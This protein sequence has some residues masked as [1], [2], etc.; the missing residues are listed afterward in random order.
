MIQEVEET[1]AKYIKLGVLVVIVLVLLFTTVYKVNAGYRGVL[2]TFGKPSENI[3]QEGINFKIP[4]VQTVKKYEVRTQKIETQADSASLDLQD[5]QTTI[6]LNFHLDPGAVNTLHQ[7]IGKDYKIRI[8]DPAIQ[9]AVKSTSAQFKAE[10]LIQKRPEVRRMM[11]EILT[12]KLSKYYIVVQ[13]FNIVNFQFSEEFDKAIE[14]KVTAEQ[15]KLKADRDLERIR[16]E[17]EQVVV[18]ADAESYSLL[19]KAEAINKNSNVVELK[20][21]EVAEKQLEVQFAFIETWDGK[22]PYVLGEANPFINFDSFE[23]LNTET[24]AE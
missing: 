21:I 1:L 9:E 8:I 5:V 18:Q 10:D 4:I 14:Q 11:K 16:V 13:D 24:S 22:M 6:A 12:E 7:K 19:K 2:L 20:R 15:L 23:G 3:A 17:A